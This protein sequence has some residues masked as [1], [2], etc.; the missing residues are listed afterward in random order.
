MT[1]NPS[2][3][4]S[5]GI[6]ETAAEIAARS[7]VY[8]PTFRFNS[9]RDVIFNYNFGYT[10]MIRG[11]KSRAPRRMSGVEAENWLMD[12]RRNEPDQYRQV[13]ESLV[14]AGYV[15]KPSRLDDVTR[16]RPDSV[17]SGW[18]R[19]LG[20]AQYEEEASSAAG[21]EPPSVMDILSQE[22]MTFRGLRPSGAGAGGP[23]RSETTSVTEYD[24]TNVMDI[25][26]NAYSQILGRRATKKERQALAQILNQEQSKAPRVT[27][28]EGTTSGGTMTGEDGQ[29]TARGTVSTTTTK[30][31]IVPTEL[32]EQK[33]IQAEDFE[34]RFFVSTFSDMLQ[35]LS[36]PF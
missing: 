18:R 14:S 28:S 12:K 26:N 3:A 10:P 20:Y 36:R 29:R 21:L 25:A 15:S 5:G 24:E 23:F 4:G 30:G 2:D 9:S 6:K 31:G 33:A 17:Q 35:E 34:E 32:A 7:N 11:A 27:I 13:V 16:I 1:V 8:E 22:A 19:F